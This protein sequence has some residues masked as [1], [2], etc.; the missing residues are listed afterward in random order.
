[1]AI[2]LDASYLLALYNESDVH[3]KR[4]VKLAERIDAN[5]YG[6]A[7]TSDDIFDEVVSVTLRKFGKEKAQNL[8]KQILDSIFIVLGDRHLFDNAFGIFN[9]SKDPFSFTDCMSRAIM[10]LAQIRRIATFDRLFE[11]LDVDVVN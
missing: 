9:D 1:M 7:I 4:A 2:F 10:D 6:Q 3:H 11:K 8:V 5:E